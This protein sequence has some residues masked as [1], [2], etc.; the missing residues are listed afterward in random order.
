MKINN[1]G[2]TLVELMGV[3]VILGILIAVGFGAYDRYKTKASNDAFDVLLKNSASAAENYFMEHPGEFEVTLE[4]KSGKDGLV[5]LNFLE[6][7]NNPYSKGSKCSGT[8]H[9]LTPKAPAITVE[10]P[11]GSSK[12]LYN[13]EQQRILENTSDAE[14]EKALDNKV[15][16]DIY[17]VSLNCGESHKVCQVF[18]AN[19]PCDA[20]TE[21][22]PQPPTVDE[23]QTAFYYWFFIGEE[24]NN[25]NYKSCDDSSYCI[26]STGFQGDKVVVPTF[27][28]N[29]YTF[30]GWFTKDGTQVDVNSLTFEEGAP[31]EFFA[32][33]EK[34]TEPEPEVPDVNP[35]YL[36]LEN[37]NFNG[38]YNMDVQIT[39]VMRVKFNSLPSNILGS[40]SCPDGYTTCTK[41]TDILSNI[42][43][44]E[45]AGIGLGVSSNNKFLIRS[46]N[47][48]LTF[49]VGASPLVFPK[50]KTFEAK[51]KKS[52]I[53]LPSYSD[54]YTIETGK[55]Y[56]VIATVK[57]KSLIIMNRLSSEMKIYINTD[58]P[59]Y[60]A[61]WQLYVLPVGYV[62]VPVPAEVPD[63]NLETNDIGVSDTPFYVGGSAD[64][65]YITN[66]SMQVSEALVF[67]KVLTSYN[68]TSY[69]SYNNKGLNQA[70]LKSI[71]KTAKTCY[72]ADICK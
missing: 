49:D 52:G 30:A 34:N 7:N 10:L 66:G 41:S 24:Y 31:N 26:E 59:A 55:W 64:G 6:N 4:S 27:E 72:P 20:Y 28:I 42:P 21:G 51:F 29:G 47:P 13:V 25:N 5:D 69:M 62:L 60:G 40:V 14:K 15:A 43:P 3:L 45:K 46:Y 12:E 71:N 68:I 70:G 8:I 67:D 18:P 1:K 57:Q 2:F 22:Y 19:I 56:T 61:E 11:D 35:Y 63:D 54:A 23:T 16:Q 39:L 58:S 48:S 50:M 38:K 65:G 44:S 37:Y 53:I 9:R 33:W 36:G 17:I 32:H